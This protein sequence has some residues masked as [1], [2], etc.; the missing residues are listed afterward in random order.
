MAVV[1]TDNFTVASDTALSSYPSAGSPDYSFVTGSD[2]TAIVSG[3]ND[4]VELAAS[5]ADKFAVI[6]NI[7]AG[8]P[9]GDEQLTLTGNCAN[10]NI[11]ELV[12]RGNTTDQTSYVASVDLNAANEVGIYSVDA[13]GTYT[14]LASADRGLSAGTHTVRFKATGTNP[15][16]LEVQV[17]STTV[18][19]Y[20]DSSAGRITSGDEGFNI[21][22]AAGTTSWVDDFIVDDTTVASPVYCAWV[23]A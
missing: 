19:T 3:A 15:V 11:F 16:L 7:H 4:R 13:G 23:T 10:T 2:T 1:F 5:G 20:S 18:V 12:L 22:A 8:L 6:R 21:F 9:S 14:T 17:D